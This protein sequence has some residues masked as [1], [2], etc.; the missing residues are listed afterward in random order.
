V[1]FLVS[2]QIRVDE[3]LKC[4]LD[5]LKRDL[6][7]KSYNQL[8]GYLVQLYPVYVAQRDVVSLVS[9]LRDGPGDSWRDRIHH[10]SV[11]LYSKYGDADI[12][13]GGDD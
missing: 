9:S 4:Q 1:I 6:G 8:L 12:G 10:M 5:D 7:L 13:V 2:Q 3:S 11:S